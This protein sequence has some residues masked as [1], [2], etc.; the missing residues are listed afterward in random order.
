MHTTARKIYEWYESR[1]E[2]YRE[3]LGASLIGH[4][5]DRYLWLT[6]RWAASPQFGGRVLRLFDTGK[7]EEARVYAEL[8]AIGVDLHTEED[9]KQIVCR[10]ET[11]HFGGSLDGIGLGFP[12]AEKTWAVLEVKTSNSKAFANLRAKGV[13]AEKPQHYAQMQTYMGMM[14]LDRAM[15]ICVNKDTDDLHTEWV[16]FDKT[17]YADL[18]HR[19]KRTIKRSTPAA[20]ISEDPAH[21]QCKMCDMYKLCHHQETAEANCRTCCHS[22]PV[23]DGKWYC[24]EFAKNL[25]VEDQRA[26]CNSHVFIPALVH[27]T[28]IDGGDNFVEYFV[29][30]TGETFKNGPA[31]TPSKE[32][33]KRGRKKA[34]KAEPVDNTPFIDDEI[35]F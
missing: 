14:E 2:N 4:K 5:C 10:D 18:L 16:R 35:P 32:V 25:S 3:H 23:A 9:G 11:G 26:G 31:H 7:R 22:T 19:A 6:F 33:A 34:S 29:E 20:K 24:N 21:W 1:K 17:A 8:R 12:E 30:G 15:Y 13:Q 28:P 27:G